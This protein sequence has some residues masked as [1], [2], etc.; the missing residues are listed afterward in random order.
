MVGKDPR[1]DP[2]KKSKCQIFVEYFY[3]DEKVRKIRASRTVIDLNSVRPNKDASVRPWT[4][5]K[6][7][8]KMKFSL[9]LGMTSFD[10]PMLHHV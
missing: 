9:I 5:F 10:E 6:E 3:R 7:I 4:E 2:Y 1:L 8:L